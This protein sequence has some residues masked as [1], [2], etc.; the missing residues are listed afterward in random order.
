MIRS[1]A[2]CVQWTFSACSP[3][4][5]RN[6]ARAQGHG[7]NASI[8]CLLFVYLF[9]CL[10]F[11]VSLL[12]ALSLTPASNI[13]IGADAFCVCA[14]LFICLFKRNILRDGKQDYLTKGKII[15]SPPRRAPPDQSKDR[16]TNEEELCSTSDR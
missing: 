14:C 3:A 6:T 13:K 5:C 10:L 1:N 7:N 9:I 4:G 2:F 16:V 11:S 15:S 12:R 8:Y